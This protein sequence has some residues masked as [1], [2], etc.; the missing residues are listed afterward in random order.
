[1]SKVILYSHGGSGNHGCEAIVRGTYKLLHGN[2]DELYSYRKDEDIKYGL[3][4]LLDVKEHIKEYPKYS[5]KRILASLKIKLFHNE[6]YA[7]KITYDALFD[8][9]KKGDIAL[10]I[11]GDN[12]CYDSFGEYELC[13]KYLK[14]KGAKTVLWE[15]SVEPSKIT[16]RMKNDL[17]NYDLIVARETITYEA[18]KKFHQNVVLC[19]DPAFQLDSRKVN[20]PKDF[21]NIVGINISPMIISNEEN[22][23]ITK[24]N[25]IQLIK[26]I[27]N[28]TDMN[29]ALIPHVVWKNNDDRQPITELYELFKDTQRVIK[30]DDYSCEELKYIISKCRLFIGARTHSTIAAYSTCVPT[31]VIGYSV[32]AKGI[33]TDLFGTYENYV[34]SVQSLK[35]E[36]DLIKPFQWLFNH[37]NQIRKHLSQYI[38]E[39]KNQSQKVNEILEVLK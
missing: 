10:S 11:G 39:Y 26:Y 16:D 22:K 27:I 37:E 31:L 23:G 35:C 1:M 18:L 19:P 12:Y 36:D 30:F 13:N 5:L 2:V 25:Y 3:N 34:I 24:K 20:L 14:K 7:E 33:A 32:K 38:I 4:K 17:L 15:C 6:E 28:N 9:V 21:D 29:V 8:N